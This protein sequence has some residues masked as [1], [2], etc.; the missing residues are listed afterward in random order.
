MLADGQLA[1]DEL[2]LGVEEHEV[3]AAGVVLARD[4]VGRLGVAAR[5][6]LVLEHAHLRAWRWCP[7]RPSATV[8]SARRSMTPVGMC[9]RRSMTRGSV[10]PGG[11]RSAFLSRSSQA[12][13]DAG[14]AR[15]PRQTAVISWSGRMGRDAAACESRHLTLARPVQCLRV[16]QA[17]ARYRAAATCALAGICA[18]CGRCRALCRA[19]IAS[20]APRTIPAKAAAA[21]R[22]QAPAPGYPAR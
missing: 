5:R 16:A 9:Q 12:R 4:L 8:G 17:R 7:A 20:S 3:E 13:P 2:A 19:P 14:E 11:S 21:S 22:R 6:R 18:G 10:T 1:L 15:R